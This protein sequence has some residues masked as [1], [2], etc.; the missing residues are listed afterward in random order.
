[1]TTVMNLETGEKQI[2]ACSPQEAV[3][4]AFAQSKGDWNTWDYKEKYSH[5]LLEGEFTFGC[6]N[7]AAFKDGIDY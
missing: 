4:A 3:I 2:Y 5:L 6:K 1:M 7:F